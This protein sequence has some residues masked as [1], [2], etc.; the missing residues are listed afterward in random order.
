MTDN[1]DTNP[2]LVVEIPDL[3]KIYVDNVHAALK[4]MIG[5]VDVRP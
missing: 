1:R 2:G 4:R 5:E 3:N